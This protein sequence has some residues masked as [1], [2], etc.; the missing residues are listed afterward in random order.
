[1]IPDSLVWPF[2]VIVLEVFFNKMIQVLI[3][4]ANEMVE[5][6]MFDRSHCMVSYWDRVITVFLEE[7]LILIRPEERYDTLPNESYAAAL[8]YDLS[9][10]P[11]RVLHTILPDVGG[12]YG[13]I[14]L[15]RDNRVSGGVS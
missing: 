5:A 6:F 7:F 13:F 1:M 4:K 14:L 8:V 15:V 2:R 12:V 11:S 3:T 9:T 10:L